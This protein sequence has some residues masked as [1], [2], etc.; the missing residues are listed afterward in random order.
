MRSTLL[1]IFFL[2]GAIASG[3][4]VICIDPGHPS[5]VGKGTR[6]KRYTE[7]QVAWDVAV[8]LKKK[9][10]SDGYKVVLTKKTQNEFVKNERRAE[11]ANAAGAA[12]MV[13]LHCDAASSRGL[14]THY[15]SQKGT[16]DGYTG[17][18][19]DVIDASATAAKTFHSVVVKSLRGFLPD[20]G[21]KT[22]LETAVG[23]KQGALTGSIYSEVP[24]LLVEMVVLTNPKDEAFL[25]NQ[26]GFE[27][28]AEALRKGV[29]ATVP[30]TSASGRPHSATAGN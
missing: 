23:K 24:V 14:A 8:R 3:Q 13:R 11:I 30:L 22:D 27:R 16:V 26:Q 29:R 18:T 10:V 15:P 4:Q 21:L 6:G 25:K 12:L 2:L 17:P 20:R 19:Q 28:L 7:I 9:L 1:S 5:E